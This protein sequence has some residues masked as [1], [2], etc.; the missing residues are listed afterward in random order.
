MQFIVSDYKIYA[1]DAQGHVIAEVTFP[2]VRKGTVTINHTY[3][4][5]SLRGQGVAGQLMIKAYEHI[6]EMGK[7]AEASCPYAVDWFAKHEECRD[8]L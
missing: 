5:P 1:K 2:E 8:I 3:V 6:K 7:K 4:D